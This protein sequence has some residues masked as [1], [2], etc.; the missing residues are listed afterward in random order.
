MISSFRCSALRAPVFQ[1]A[2][3][4]APGI[5]PV[6]SIRSYLPPPRRQT[7][8]V[9]VRF[10]HT[11]RRSSSEH[12]GK[13]L[14]ELEDV[15]SNW[16]RNMNRAGTGLSLLG[17]VYMALYA[18]LYLEE[19]A[20]KKEDERRAKEIEK[21]EEELREKWKKENAE[22]QERWKTQLERF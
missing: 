6:R 12:V 19:R 14:N 13:R 20:V 10:R 2:R 9:Q 1:V 16:K 22:R 8:L 3:P 4:T 15:V 18:W 5:V 17:Y 21:R 7:E 11:R